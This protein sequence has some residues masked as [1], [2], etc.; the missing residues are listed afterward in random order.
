MLTA[1][2]MFQFVKSHKGDTTF[3]GYTDSEIWAEIGEGLKNGTMLYTT[4]EDQL[5]GALFFF[6]IPERQ[7]VFVHENLAMTR[8]NLRKFFRW[9]LEK[10]PGWKLEANK[11]GKYKQYNVEKLS[12][13]L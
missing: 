1:A 6:L 12:K 11:H 7:V 2:D 3:M 5:T 10:F 8:E 4:E 9:F 13:K